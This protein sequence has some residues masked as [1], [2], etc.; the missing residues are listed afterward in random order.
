MGPIGRTRLRWITTLFAIAVVTQVIARIFAAVPWG[1]PIANYLIES[2]KALGRTAASDAIQWLS[3]PWVCGSQVAVAQKIDLTLALNFAGCMAMFPCSILGY[4][5]VDQWCN[6][7]VHRR[8]VRLWKSGV[9]SSSNR[10]LGKLTNP[11]TRWHRFASASSMATSLRWIDIDAAAIASRVATSVSKYRVTLWFSFLI[12]TALC[13]S[14]LI[15]PQVNSP[16]FFVVG[17]LATCTLLLAP[18]SVR[19]DFRR[20][21]KRL[22]LLKSLPI[23]PRSMVLGQLYFP[24]VVT[25]MF[26]GFVLFVAALV[27]RPGFT[28]VSLWTGMLMALAVFVF[29]MENSIFLAYPHSQHDQGMMMMIRSKLA[30]LGKMTLA[31]LAL[32]ALGTWAVFCKSVF[33]D[34]LV[35]SAVVAGALIATWSIAW[36][37]VAIMTSLWRR[38][39]PSLMTN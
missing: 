14:P 19:L 12:P 31:A 36:G 9:G 8:E 15:S 28:S 24:V 32:V 11:R 1:A 29:A 7:A 33:P 16:W 23:S 27:L 18:A 4:V 26:Q 10:R 39:N 2:L 22:E 30:F 34:A 20:D 35:P 5:L 21:F 37:S 25:W 3:I 6:Q 17:G 13:L 38:W